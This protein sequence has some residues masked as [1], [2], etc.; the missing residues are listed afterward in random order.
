MNCIGV[1][2]SSWILIG[3][4]IVLRH[5]CKPV[6]VPDWLGCQIDSGSCAYRWRIDAWR[7]DTSQRTKPG[8]LVYKRGSIMDLKRR[9]TPFWLW[10]HWT[11]PVPSHKQSHW[12]HVWKHWWMHNPVPVRDSYSEGGE[13]KCLHVGRCFDSV[14]GALEIKWIVPFS[15]WS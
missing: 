1:D 12:K 6:W 4:R 2:V 5:G 7:I 9:L 13:R 11:Q 15:E 10:F 3:C 8:R 14:L